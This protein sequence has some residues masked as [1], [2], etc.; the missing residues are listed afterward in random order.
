MLGSVPE[1]AADALRDGN[2]AA[3]ITPPPAATLI[4]RKVRRVIIGDEGRDSIS[5]GLVAM[6]ASFTRAE[7]R[8][9]A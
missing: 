3:N 7:V 4:A 2:V 5:D 9:D 6:G 8:Q 1:T